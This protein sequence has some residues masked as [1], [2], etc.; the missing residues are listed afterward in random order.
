MPYKDKSKHNECQRNYIRA[1][2]IK[3][4]G[5]R[6]CEHCGSDY[7][8]NIHHVNPEDK[9]SHRIWSWKDNR[10]EAELEK[11]IVLCDKCHRQ[12][13]NPRTVT[14]GSITMYKRYRC[15]C[16]DCRKANASYERDRRAG[17]KSPAV[18]RSGSGNG[19]AM[20]PGPLGG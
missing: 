7:R 13:H 16:D 18:Q 14:H 15:R 4:L 8:L 5:G 19:A 11:C 3:Y 9:V 2:R 17:A 6:S 20:P 1:N 10:I 12:F